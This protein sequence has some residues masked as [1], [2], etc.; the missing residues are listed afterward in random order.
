[1]LQE[2]HGNGMNYT[3][4]QHTPNTSESMRVASDYEKRVCSK[5]VRPPCTDQYVR[6]KENGDDNTG[7]NGQP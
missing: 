4:K 7:I 1:M 3:R 5:R 2:T 6:R